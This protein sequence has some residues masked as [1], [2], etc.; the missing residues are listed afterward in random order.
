MLHAEL[1][2]FNDSKALFLHTVSLLRGGTDPVGSLVG[3][4]RL[5]ADIAEKRGEAA[6]LN[7]CLVT[8]RRILALRTSTGTEYNSLYWSTG[9]SGQY[10]ASEPLDDT[11]SWVEVPEDHLVEICCDQARIRPISDV[12][13]QVSPGA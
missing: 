3:A 6:A 5:T 12:A 11:E 9:E 13:A 2:T 4:A 10:V 1:D 8:A 7:L